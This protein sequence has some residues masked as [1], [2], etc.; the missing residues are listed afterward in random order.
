MRGVG[1]VAAVQ[2]R[3]TGRG[4]LH[5]AQ[6]ENNELWIITTNLAVDRFDSGFVAAISEMKY[7]YIYTRGC[8]LEER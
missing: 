3:A 5:T 6:N 1:N 2:A 7:I 4:G 8:Q